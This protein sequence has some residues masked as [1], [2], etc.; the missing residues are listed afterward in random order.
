MSDKLTVAEK[1]VR[2]AATKKQRSAALK[3]LD[4][5]LGIKKK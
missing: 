5:A 3:D 2:A 1:K 4:K